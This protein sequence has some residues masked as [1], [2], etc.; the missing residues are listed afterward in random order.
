MAKPSF[1]VIYNQDCSNLFYTT[2]E[3]IKPHHVDRMVDEVALGGAE[4]FL[5]CPNAQ[6]V[7]YPSSVWQTFWDGVEPTSWI[8]KAARLSEQ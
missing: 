8:Q 3:P 7:V 4:V 1:R 5:V 6:R 2:K